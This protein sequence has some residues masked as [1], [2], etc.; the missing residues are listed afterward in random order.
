MFVIKINTRLKSLTL[1]KVF[2]SPLEALRSFL[3]ITLKQLQHISMYLHHHEEL[4]QQI[5]IMII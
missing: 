1:I 4:S 5:L 2:Y 3:N